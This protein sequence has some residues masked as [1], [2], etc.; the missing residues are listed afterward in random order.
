MFTGGG[1]RATSWILFKRP[2][3]WRLRFVSH[4]ESMGWWECEAVRITLSVARIKGAGSFLRLIFFRSLA[5]W[6][7]SSQ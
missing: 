1:S 3:S 2:V 5:C 6:L 7:C 4:W